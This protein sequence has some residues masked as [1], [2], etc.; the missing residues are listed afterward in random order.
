LHRQSGQ[1]VV[2][3]RDAT[4][5]RR[6][7][8][9]GKHDTPESR[10]E[11]LRVLAEWEAA[12]RQL[13][14]RGEGGTA[15]GDLSVDELILRFWKHAE[16]HYRH[17]DGRPTTELDGFR[18]SLRPLRVLYGGTLAKDFGPLALKAVRQ[19]MA[20]GS[21]MPEEEKAKRQEAG[22]PAG[23]SRALVNQ[24]VRRIVRMFK[25][26]VSEELVQEP[27]Y[28][29]LTTVRGLEKGRTEARETEPVGPVSESHALAVLPFVLPPVAAMVQLQVL[30]GMRPGEACVMRACDID[31]SGAVWLYRPAQHKTAHRAR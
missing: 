20:S 10:V 16:Q 11:Y 3:L 28:R 22:K 30:T 15:P 14:P 27:V 9:L 4:G 18:F 26:A 17:P 29:A 8:L 31:L 2:T 13:S 24:R 5:R 21:W 7:L 12:G 19:A 1:A 25:W 23:L 6:D